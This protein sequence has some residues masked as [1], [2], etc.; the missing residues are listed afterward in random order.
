MYKKNNKPL[1]SIIINCHNGEAFL[2]ECLLSLKKQTYNNFEII[3]WDNASTDK[4]KLIY[5]SFKDKRFKY[6][7]SKKKTSLYKARNLALKKINGDYI[8]FIDTD[9]LW[10]KN[11]I[12]EQ[13]I[14]FKDK[15][16]DIVYSNA[17]LFNIKNQKKKIR[18]KDKL[19]SGYIFDDQFKNFYCTITTSLI[20]AS[21]LRNLQFNEKYNHIGD[22]DFFLKL[23]KKF[24]FKSISKPLVIYRIHSSNL[25]TLKRLSEIKEKEEWLKKNFQILRNK[26]MK[27]FKE[28]ISYQKFLYNKLSSNLLSSFLLIFKDNNTNF[29]LFLK[30][31]FVFFLPNSYLKK[32]LWF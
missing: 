19:P 10:N 26:Y 30:K 3:F 9:D 24:F 31:I 2:N 18:F 4:S 32:N 27:S 12:K 29:Y 6:F 14:K 21:I 5:K 1:I 11:K 16:V 22:F 28:K 25:S 7:F 17:L 8:S 20:K 13:L 23:S 15:K